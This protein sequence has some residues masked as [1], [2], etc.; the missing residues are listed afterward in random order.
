MD[1]RHH[2][3]FIRK[4]INSDVSPDGSWFLEF[5]LG[6]EEVPP[7]SEGNAQL[8]QVDAV[9]LTSRSNSQPSSY[10]STTGSEPS[11]QQFRRLWETEDFAGEPVT[12]VEAKTHGSTMEGVGQLQTYKALLEDEWSVRVE[13]QI[14]LVPYKDAIISKACS[15]LDIDI[16]LFQ[17]DLSLAESRG[18]SSGRSNPESVENNL[19]EVADDRPNPSEPEKVRDRLGPFATPYE[20]LERWRRQNGW[21]VQKMWVMQGED[22]MLTKEQWFAGRR[23]P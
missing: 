3:E 10:I 13:K 5:P 17:P 20:T 12:M 16:E 21:S 9:C 18:R 15:I 23:D 4:Y 14:L 11:N 19:S 8:K 22:S 1:R 7:D 2:D 6:F